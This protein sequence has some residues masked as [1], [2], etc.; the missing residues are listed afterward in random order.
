MPDP[1]L[2]ALTTAIGFGIAPVLLKVAFQRGG[3]MTLG[4]VIG[5]VATVLLTIAL[6]PFM[7]ARFGELTWTSVVAFILGGLAGTGIGRIWAYQSINILGPSRSNTI[8]SSSPVITTILAML[9]LHED[10]STG[11]WLAVAAVVGGAMLVSWN[12]A[13]GAR[14]WLGKGVLYAFAAAAIYGVRPLIVK[15][16]LDEVNA[17]LAA[18][19]VGSVAA[20]VYTL[21]VEDRGPLRSI[22]VDSAF[23]WFL[24]SG[25]FQAVAITALAFGLSGGDASLVYSL[26]ASAPLFTLVFTWLLLRDVEPVTPRLVA[27]TL[28]VV[29]GVIAL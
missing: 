16:G 26:T 6:V 15:W 23:R 3:G 29:A 4:L 18:A 24:A 10:V 22:G 11:R 21:A 20:L 8:R 1:K 9:L 19:L 5:Q 12:P 2:M 28:A 25:V 13:E 7:D 14:G 27:G 17:P